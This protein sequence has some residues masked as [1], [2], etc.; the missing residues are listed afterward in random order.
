MIETKAM[1]GTPSHGPGDHEFNA[2]V[3]LLANCLKDVRGLDCVVLRNGY[4]ADDSVLDTADGILCFA[5]GGGNHP[6]IRGQR[7]T[8]IGAL[9]DKGVGLMCAHYG[10]EVPRDL[11]YAHSDSGERAAEAVALAVWAFR[12]ADA[13]NPSVTRVEL[14]LGEAPAPSAGFA[15]QL[16][17]ALALAQEL[18]LEGIEPKRVRK[19]YQ[20]MRDADAL[21][22]LRA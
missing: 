22:I 13:K 9:M 21:G 12:A 17:P 4:P 1:A 16:S 5:D 10:V 6:L 3:M 7:L 15:Q 8:R 20:P 11:G 2:G 19:R 14:E 18:L